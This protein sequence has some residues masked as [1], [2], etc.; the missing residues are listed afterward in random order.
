M[1][2]LRLMTRFYIKSNLMKLIPTSTTDCSRSAIRTSSMKTR[3]F[4][5]CVLEI[6]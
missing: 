1:K 3:Y 4:K 6:D 5:Y 2:E